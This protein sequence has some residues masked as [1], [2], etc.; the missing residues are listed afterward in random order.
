[1]AKVGHV[2]S[3][4]LML[5]KGLL[6]LPLLFFVVVLGPLLQTLVLLRLALAPAA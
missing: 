1:M 3:L 6:S 2:L 4:L 5:V